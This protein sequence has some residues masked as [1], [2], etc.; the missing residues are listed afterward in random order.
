MTTSDQ[1]INSIVGKVIDEVHGGAIEDSSVVYD[2]VEVVLGAV[3]ARIAELEAGQAEV[4]RPAPKG[5]NGYGLDAA[6]FH[7]KLSQIIREIDCF[8]PSEMARALARYVV[9]ADES[10]LREPEFQQQ[11]AVPEGWGPRLREKVIELTNLIPTEDPAIEPV[12][13]DMNRARED[14][15]ALIAQ[16]C[17]GPAV[18]EGLIVSK[19]LD[20]YERRTKNLPMQHEIPSRGCSTYNWRMSVIR[21]LRAMLAAPQPDVEVQS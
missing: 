19:L 12:F 21:D 15:F 5:K 10:V 8:T 18:P 16:A 2:T 7:K 4:Q 13:E 17:S 11:P 14:L 20:E 3:G 1:F 6:Y 9:V